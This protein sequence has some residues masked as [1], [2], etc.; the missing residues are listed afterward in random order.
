M[1][2]H[3]AILPVIIPLLGGIFMLLPG[4]N[5][6][7][8][9]LRISAF[10][11]SLIL[12][13]ACIILGWYVHI[14][15]TQAYALG[16]WESPFGIHLYVDRLAVTLSLLTTFIL[17]CTQI[18]SFAGEDKQGQYYHPLLMFQV[19]GIQGAFLTGDIFNLFVFFEVLLIASYALLI[20]GGGKQKTQANVHYVILNLAGSAFFLFALG[21]IYGT[22]GTLNMVD[23]Q[24]KAAN[25]APDDVIL[26]KS[27]ALLLLVVFGLKSAM[28]P[29]HF[30][31]PKAYSAAPA[32]VAALFSIM[33]KVGIY[34]LWRVH[35]GIFGD[36]AGE[37]ANIANPWIL[38][39]ALLTLFAGSI[40]ALSSQS[41]RTLTAN[42]VIISVGS[43][44]LMVALNTQQ[45][46]SAGLYYLLHSTIATAAMFLLAGIIIR[47][48]G[49]AEDRFVASRSLNHSG[50]LG[51]LFFLCAIALIGMPPLSGFIGKA[52]MLKAALGSEYVLWIWPAILLASLAAMIILSRAGSTIFW[53]TKGTKTSSETLHC[54]ELSSVILLLVGIVAL[55][56]FANYITA[57][58]QLAAEQLLAFSPALSEDTLR[59]PA[60][61]LQ[62][63]A[64]V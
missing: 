55:V 59:I 39:F 20:H 29:L 21:I 9:R 5:H 31:L 51:V 43:L 33:T 34:S 11:I 17:I 40:A 56:V 53:R 15:G 1:I 37:L 16:N 28:L 12:L 60:E 3:L 38:P 25:L 35:N 50:L 47:L 26:A 64:Y 58:C 54:L 24:A 8:V 44:L 22:F 7:P 42:L 46:T 36:Q 48:R 6:S 63:K 19:M 18:Y 23:L 14:H 30:W 45:A 2:T 4:F 61:R 62:E 13:G 27:G 10:I 49:K 57:F 41:L 52:L 32:S